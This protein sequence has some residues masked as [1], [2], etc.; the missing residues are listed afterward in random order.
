LSEIR[1]V[2]TD[3]LILCGGLGTRFK[4]VR[5]DIPKALAPVQG[6]PF[7][8]LLLDDLIGQGFRR[9]ILATGHLG[10]LL[11]QHVTQRIDAEYIVSCEPKPLGTGGAIKFAGTHFNSD[12]VL[13]MNGDTKIECNFS[14]LLIHHMKNQADMTVLLSKVVG[15]TDYGNIEINNND[16]IVNFI[17]KPVA[18]KTSLANAGVYL[19]NKS[20]LKSLKKNHNYSLEKDCL[21]SWINSHNIFGYISEAIFQDIGT[22]ERYNSFCKDV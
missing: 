12:P 17:E 3:A 4:V 8:D 11:H 5:E 1:K 7:I 19:I 9:I 16:R 14:D 15:G 22:P 2:N 6:N 20:L 10:D 21:P 13:V 18:M